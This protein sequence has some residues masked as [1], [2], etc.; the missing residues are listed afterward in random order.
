MTLHL[1]ET[2][3]SSAPTL[4]FIHGGGGAGWMWKPQLSALTDF[5]CLV[6]DLPE[7]G[8][9]MAEKP[10][11]IA[12]SADLLADLIRSRAHQGKATVVGLS[13]GAQVGLEM[14]ARYPGQVER[15]ILSSPLV[16][17]MPSAEMITS[18]LVAW[19]YRWFVAPFKRNDWWVRIN[20]KYA[21]GVP[22]TYFNDFRRSF[23][24]L[25]ES[26]FTNLMVE[27]QRFRLPVGLE[28]ATNPTLVVCGKSEY[29]AMRQSVREVAAA[30]PNGRAC[31]VQ[32]PQ[33]LSLAEEH[34]WNLTAPEL[35]TAMVRAWETGQPLPAALM[36]L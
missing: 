11:S 13:E 24:E 36:P 33:K 18:D 30:L 25:T 7:Q 10:F 29:P 32:H 31:A 16:R 34:N 8:Q 1:H 27:N 5:H 23:Q 12:R 22:E 21:A 4:L 9:S 2:G 35:F 28:Q 3:N 19:S 17:P 20:M 15:A 26:G 14:L 6:P